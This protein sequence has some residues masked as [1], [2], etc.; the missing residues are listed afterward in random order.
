MRGT[1]R[2]VSLEAHARHDLGPSHDLVALLYSI[3]GDSYSEYGSFSAS[4]K[5]GMWKVISVFITGRQ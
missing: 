3:V 4:E 2:Y 1:L 5:R